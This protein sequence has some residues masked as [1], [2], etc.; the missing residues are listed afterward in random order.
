M[1]IDILEKFRNFLKLF[2]FSRFFPI[3]CPFAT[4]LPNNFSSKNF[5]WVKLRRWI[6]SPDKILPRLS[7]FNNS[8]MGCFC[9]KFWHKKKGKVLTISGCTQLC[10]EFMAIPKRINTLKDELND[11]FTNFLKFMTNFKI[12]KFSKILLTKMLIFLSECTNS[13]YPIRYY[14]LIIFSPRTLETPRQFIH[15][16][17]PKV[18]CICIS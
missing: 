5:W 10:I 12:A 1:Q 14:W 9:W 3:F 7:T 16:N 17:C 18:I 15:W 6:P 11:W 4:F 13:G 2:Y 8:F